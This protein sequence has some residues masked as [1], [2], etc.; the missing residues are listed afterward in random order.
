MP[1]SRA[2]SMRPLLSVIPP[3]PPV[4]RHRL[5]LQDRLD[6]IKFSED[7]P[8][9]TDSEVA[10]TLRR[11]GYITLCQAT[12]WR[13]KNSKDKL[14]ALAKNLNKLRFKRRHQVEYPDIDQ[15][16]QKWILQK[17]GGRTRL[18][19]N[20]IH[21]KARQFAKLFG[22]PDDFLSLSD[23]WLDSLKACMGL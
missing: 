2:T 10:W 19:G 7:H 1:V 20:I 22:Y 15:A 5:T 3:K 23:G 12:V 18:S 21:I 11:R 8:N 17:Q 9:L 14:R 4:K 6:V 13:Y 16:L